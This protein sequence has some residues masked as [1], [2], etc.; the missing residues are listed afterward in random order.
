MRMVGALHR[1]KHK[2]RRALTLEV[3]YV[4]QA[5]VGLLLTHRQSRAKALKVQASL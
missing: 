3:V 2:V 4:W 5:A 1:N